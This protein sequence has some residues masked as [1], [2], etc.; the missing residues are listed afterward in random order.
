MKT[1]LQVIYQEMDMNNNF[2][3]I[4]KFSIVDFDGYHLLHQQ[5]DA[6][7]IIQSS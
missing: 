1:M 2:L 7:P 4:H 3:L 6:I 5:I